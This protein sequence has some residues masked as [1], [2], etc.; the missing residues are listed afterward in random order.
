M[1]AE[2][3]MAVFCTSFISRFPGMLLRYCVNDFEMVPVASVIT[4]ITF[5]LTFYTRR[6]SIIR[7]LYSKIFS[8]SYLIT[9]LC[10]GIATSINMHVPFLLT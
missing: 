8:V 10:P 7:S 1:C 5:T 2:P 4:G 6:I 3:N 9:F